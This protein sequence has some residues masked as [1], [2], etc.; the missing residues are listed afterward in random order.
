LS[1][2]RKPPERSQEE[3]VRTERTQREGKLR[4]RV[5]RGEEEEEEKKKEEDEDQLHLM[6]AL[7]YLPPQK[8]LEF[9][10]ALPQAG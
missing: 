8:D 9:I 7:G 2:T 1:W 4:R 5:R 10:R 3:N 6:I